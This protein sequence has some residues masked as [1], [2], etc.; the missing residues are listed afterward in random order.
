MASA[1]ILDPI[2]SRYEVRW[3]AVSMPIALQKA[4][5]GAPYTEQIA[6][7]AAGSVSSGAWTPS[8]RRDDRPFLEEV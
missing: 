6:D 8:T 3:I 5:D 4:Q 1:S 2:S 7:A